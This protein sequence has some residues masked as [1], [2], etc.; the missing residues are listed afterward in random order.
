[1]LYK[2]KTLD[3]A[4]QS[5]LPSPKPSL[6][7]KHPQRKSFQQHFFKLFFANTKVTAHKNF[8]RQ[9]FAILKAEA[10]EV[11]VVILVWGVRVKWLSCFFV[12]A[13][14]CWLGASRRGGGILTVFMLVTGGSKP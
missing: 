7:L 13:Q 3:S 9:I 10:N 5:N 12:V 8:R 2:S 14:F 4:Q 11:Y 6:P 1:V